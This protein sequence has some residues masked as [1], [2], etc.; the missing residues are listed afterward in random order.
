MK[1]PDLFFSSGRPGLLPNIVRTLKAKGASLRAT[2][3]PI[4]T[5]TAAGKCF[6]DML[7]VFAEFETNCGAS[8]SLKVSR[9]MFSRFAISVAPSPF[10]LE[11]F[12]LYLINGRLPALVHPALAL[13]F[14]ASPGFCVFPYAFAPPAREWN[15]IGPDVILAEDLERLVVRRAS[16]VNEIV[17]ALLPRYQFFHSLHL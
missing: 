4:D 3:Q 16:L 8:V 10:G 15:H 13:A 7:G 12:H 1:K 2:E 9:P 14:D 5:S 17:D 11:F 6:L